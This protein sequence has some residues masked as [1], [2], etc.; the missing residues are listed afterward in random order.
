MDFTKTRADIQQRVQKLLGRKRFQHT[1]GV[2]QTAESLAR[3]Y[4][5]SVEKAVISA[6]LHD[7]ARDLSLNE[8]KEAILQNDPDAQFPDQLLLEPVLLHAAAGAAIARVRFGIEDHEILRSIMLH[9][10]G[11]AGMGLL[12]RVVFVADFIEPGRSM[13]GVKR[14]R[15]LAW[16]NLDA[17]TLLILRLVLVYL[18]DR[19]KT[20]VIDSIDAYNDIILHRTGR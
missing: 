7:I 8:M 10:T 13:K 9:T 17:A 16:E 11:G 5:C 20:I 19:E 1:L 12:E 15:R 14:V 4:G 6:L 18:L 3:H 2:C